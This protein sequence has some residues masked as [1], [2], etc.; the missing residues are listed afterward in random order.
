VTYVGI[1]VTDTKERVENL[2]AAVVAGS[3]AGVV[4]SALD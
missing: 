1:V 2:P 3:M 4:A